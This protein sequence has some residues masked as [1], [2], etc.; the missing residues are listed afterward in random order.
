MNINDP[1]SECRERER[2][3]RLAEVRERQQER[4]RALRLQWRRDN[5]AAAA[6]RGLIESASGMSKSE[7]V[8]HAKD[9]AD[10][11]LEVLDGKDFR[12]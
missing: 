6:M 12:R 8:A 9:F 2:Q 11:M 1:C 3:Q 7:I 10:R 4:Q 5:F